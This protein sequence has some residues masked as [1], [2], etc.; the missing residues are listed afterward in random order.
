MTFNI[1]ENLI[2]E[3]YSFEDNLSALEL[4]FLICKIFYST[5][6]SALYSYL[7]QDQKIEPWI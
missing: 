6:F 1:L 5:N 7:M 3:L 4:V 2:N